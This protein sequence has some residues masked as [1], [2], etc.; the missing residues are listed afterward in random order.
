MV[1]V[2]GSFK[3]A[4]VVLVYGLAEA[5]GVNADL[6]GEFLEGVGSLVAE[7]VQVEGHGPVEDLG[8]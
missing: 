5:G 2:S 8:L 7:S 3:D 6:G 1:G 4:L